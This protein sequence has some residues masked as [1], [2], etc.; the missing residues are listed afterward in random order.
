MLFLRGCQWGEGGGRNGRL[1]DLGRKLC[2]RLCAK[3]IT[4]DNSAIAGLMLGLY[5][6]SRIA[7]CGGVHGREFW[8][9]KDGLGM[10]RGK[11]RAAESSTGALSPSHRTHR[12]AATRRLL[13][14]RGQ[15]ETNRQ[16]SR[17]MSGQA[18]GRAAMEGL[19]VGC[20]PFTK[21]R[22]DQPRPRSG[23]RSCSHHIPPTS[24]NARL[25]STNHSKMTD[26]DIWQRVE[27]CLLR[28]ALIWLVI[29]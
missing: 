23:C 29:V 10:C 15:V 28:Q 24:L 8:P 22:P 16:I 25:T 26:D 14:S 21:M 18:G 13:H 7:D 12:I 1:L 20:N 3:E 6:D 4:E 5:V 19:A 17:Q 2:V 9:P 27:H 11:S